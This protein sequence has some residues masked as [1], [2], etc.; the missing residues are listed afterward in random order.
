[1]A[2][3]A[4]PFEPL[5]EW[6]DHRPARGFWQ[7]WYR[8]PS[9]VAGLIIIGSLILMS[10]F[11]PV[12]ASHS[13]TDQDLQNILKGPSSEHWLGTDQLGRDLWSRMVYA[14]RTD[15]KIGFL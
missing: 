13:P 8:T 7:R 6:A 14:G 12:V 9:F 5:E 11:A 15:L 1:M 2:T 3:V 4:E 10:I